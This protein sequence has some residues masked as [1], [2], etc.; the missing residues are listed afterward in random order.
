MSRDD[1]SLYTGVSSQSV[2]KQRTE[3]AEEKAEKRIKLT[4]AGDIVAAEFKK[5]ID[6]LIYGPYK[7]EDAMSDEQFRAERKGRR[8]AVASL[9]GI[10]N[11][12]KNLLREPKA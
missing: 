3:K 7:D 1:S 8:L 9:V 11:R 5:E 6:A 10:Q 12:L 4:P 2:A